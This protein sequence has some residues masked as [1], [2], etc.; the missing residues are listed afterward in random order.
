MSKSWPGSLI[1]K[2]PVTP[3]GPYQDGAA[4]G[5]WT[6]SEQAYWNKQGLWPTAGRSLYIAVAHESSPYI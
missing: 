6:L 2:T 1:T 3:A 5:V 4:P